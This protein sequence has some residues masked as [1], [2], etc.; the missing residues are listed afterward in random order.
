MLDQDK[1]MLAITEADNEDEE[2]S[3]E[4]ADEQPS[5]KT[6]FAELV[7]ILRGIM[8]NGV[9]KNYKV[10]RLAAYT[11]FPRLFNSVKPILKPHQ[12]GQILTLMESATMI[13]WG[14]KK[15]NNESHLMQLI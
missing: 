8:M 14:E 7:R 11:L 3:K 1:K 5:Q 13:E 12:S 9:G 10:K 2:E 6:M 15:G 4:V